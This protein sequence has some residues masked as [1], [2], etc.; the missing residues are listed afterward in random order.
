MQDVASTETRKL[1]WVDEEEIDVASNEMGDQNEAIAA[2]T[3]DD[4][5]DDDDEADEQ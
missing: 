4:E 3:K 5:E 2:E 1:E